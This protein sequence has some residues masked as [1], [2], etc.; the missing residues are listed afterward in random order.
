MSVAIQGFSSLC[1]RALNSSAH[2]AM[3]VFDLFPRLVTMAEYK[4]PDSTKAEAVLDGLFAASFKSFK[5]VYWSEQE[6]HR[7]IHAI[8]ICMRNTDRRV[9]SAAQRVHGK[10][11][12]RLLQPPPIANE[13]GD[14]EKV[15]QPP[16]SANEIGDEKKVLQPPPRANEM[17]DEEKL[18]Q[19]PP[20]RMRW[21]SRRRWQGQSVD[22]VL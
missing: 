11:L 12:K 3:S 19:P 16:P 7:N 20:K 10:W 4:C 14:K 21:A 2:S 15:L 17:G 8:E 9:R 1:Q 13:M 5:G 6:V 18:F 22:A